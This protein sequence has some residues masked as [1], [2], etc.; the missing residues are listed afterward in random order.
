VALMIFLILVALAGREVYRALTGEVMYDLR[1]DP[2][3]GELKTY[4]QELPEIQRIE[5]IFRPD[6]EWLH[7]PLRKPE[8]EETV[9]AITDPQE[10]RQIMEGFKE[11]Q[12]FAPYWTQCGFYLRLDLYGA[13]GKVGTLL[14]GIDDCKSFTTPAIHAVGTMANDFFYREY[15]I[16]LWESHVEPED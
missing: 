9:L 4:V 6:R 7:E 2:S 12:R 13:Q 15:V 11:A 5:V 16:P 8:Y 14:V 3:I 1:R 10:I